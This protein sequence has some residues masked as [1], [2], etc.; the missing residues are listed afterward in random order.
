MRK[1]VSPTTTHFYKA[2]LPTYRLPV[3]RTN[4]PGIPN[5]SRLTVAKYPEGKSVG[6]PAR[7]TI[8]HGP[9]RAKNGESGAQAAP[10]ARARN[11]KKRSLHQ[12]FLREYGSLHQA[13]LREYGS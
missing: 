8:F 12:A 11:L 7:E 5:S 9:G 6:S 3:R 4:Y 13:F 2:H 10:T 1:L